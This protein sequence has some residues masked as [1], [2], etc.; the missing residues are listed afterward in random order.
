MVGKLRS[1]D[2]LVNKAQELKTKGL[3]T[4]EISDQLKVQAD[5]VVWLLLKGKERLESCIDI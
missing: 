3:T 1:L 4:H 5:T 2:D